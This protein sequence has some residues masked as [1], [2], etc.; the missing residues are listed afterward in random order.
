MTT[1]AILQ[2][3]VLQQAADAGRAT[4]TTLAHLTIGEVVIP[5]EMMQD[6]EVQQAV[7][8][9]FQA[10]GI[11]PGEYTVGHPENKINP[12]TGYPEFFLGKIFKGVKRIFKK[13]APIALPILGSMIPGVGPVLGAALG[14]AAGGA[15]SGGGLKGVLTG[16]ALGGL[17]GYAAGGAGGLMGSAPETIA[18]NQGGSSLLNAGSGIRGILAGGNPSIV[19]FAQG[20]NAITGSGG[21][22]LASLLGGG[23]STGGSL[24]SIGNIAR[25]GGSLY[26]G[27][28]DQ[29]AME[30]AEQQMLAAQGKAAGALRPY[31]QMGLD[32]QKQLSQNLQAGFNP[33]NLTSD[34]GYQFRLQQGQDALNRTLAAQG[35]GQSGAAMKSAQ[36]YGQ[37]MAATEYGNA[38]DRWLAQ[39][40]QLA[41]M[42]SQGLD[43]AGQM[44]GIYGNIGNV[45][46]ASTLGLQ[47]RKNR[48]IAEI[49]AGLG[50]A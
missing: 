6:E 14:G 24:G 44:G 41:G 20:G 49:L 10:Y 9:I 32:A 12:E 35:M 21:G 26:S 13:V 29:D 38:Y 25:I 18:W 50:Y 45:Q 1:D 27:G 17:G 5:A 48:T 4:D 31:S 7:M 11:S 33:G 37:G 39:N 8:A 2:D 36:E 30:K 19:K 43:T 22:G 23:G 40:R 16:A 15:V 34:P 46:G 42:G 28:Q 3:Q 47:E